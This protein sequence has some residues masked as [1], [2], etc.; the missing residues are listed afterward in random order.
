MRLEPCAWPPPCTGN[1]R[2]GGGGGD[3]ATGPGSDAATSG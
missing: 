1:T 3:D 2:D